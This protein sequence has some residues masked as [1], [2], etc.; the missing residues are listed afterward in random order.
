[1]DVS[2]EQLK[3]DVLAPILRTFYAEVRTKKGDMYSKSGYINLRSGLQRHLSSPQYGCTFNIMNDS[4][5]QQANQVYQG[6][7]KKLKISGKDQTQHKVAVSSADYEKLTEYFANSIDTPK[8][9]QQKVF[10]DII[11]QF[12]RRGREGLRELH[13][14][15]FV[16]LK[17]GEGNEYA[18]LGYHEFDKNHADT[19]SR[20]SAETDKRMYAEPGE[21][22]C[23]VASLKKYISLLNPD[24]DSFFQRPSKTTK[25]PWYDNMPLGRCT[26]GTYMK[27]LS[28]DAGLSTIYTNHCLRASTVT[29]LKRQGVSNSDICSVTGHKREESLVNYC[30]EPSDSRKRELSKMLH[31]KGKTPPENITKPAPSTSNAESLVP[32]ALSSSTNSSLYNAPSVASADLARS[33][34]AG[35]IFHGPVNV[36]VNVQGSKVHVQNEV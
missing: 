5:F 14:G 4:V 9:L 26:L 12:G 19:D 25:G 20:Q 10:F 28:Q 33:M 11:F 8:G 1:M 13:K 30:K 31:S 35:S 36:T 17:D 22:D 32:V 27:K 7:L 21:A 3:P 6:Q 15:S 34:F 16:F 24:N 18:K 29:F 2:F 23:P